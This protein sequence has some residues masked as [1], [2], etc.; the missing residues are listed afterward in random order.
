MPERTVLLSANDA[1]RWDASVQ[2]AD[3]MRE[4]SE[5]DIPA[6]RPELEEQPPDAPVV[7]IEPEHPILE[8]ESAL[9]AAEEGELPLPVAQAADLTGVEIPLGAGL[10]ITAQPEPPA[11]RWTNVSEE[12]VTPGPAPLTAEAVSLAFQRDGRRYDNGFPLY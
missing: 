3:G 2:S 10:V 5:K 4:K 7:Q 6:V 12:L 8:T 1:E 11:S 9:T